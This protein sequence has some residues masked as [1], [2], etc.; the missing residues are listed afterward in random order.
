MAERLEYDK[1]SGQIEVMN[2]IIKLLYSIIEFD[3]EYFDFYD[4][5][6]LLKRKTAISF[7][8]N[9][10]IRYLET[11]EQEDGSFSVRFEDKWYRTPLEFY[12]NARIDG[13]QITTIYNR[14]YRYK[15]ID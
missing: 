10:K 4:I 15:M 6:Y 2:R 13:K 7:Y 1:F 12:S 14:F 9:D 8:Y 3:P 11:E 5:M